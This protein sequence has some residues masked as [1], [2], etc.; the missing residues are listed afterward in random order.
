MPDKVRLDLLTK[1]EITC[2]FDRQAIRM[3]RRSRT[4]D[5]TEATAKIIIHLDG[6][7]GALGIKVTLPNGSQVG[8]VMFITECQLDNLPW[9]KLSA[10]FHRYVRNHRQGIRKELSVA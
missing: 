7:K 1:P 8:Y 4:V 6:E 10:S 5:F 9:N 3:I 2:A